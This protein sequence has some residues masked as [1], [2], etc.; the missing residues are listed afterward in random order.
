MR[1]T[2]RTLNNTATKY[3]Q[4]KFDNALAVLILT[5]GSEIWNIKKNKQKF[6]LQKLNFRG[7]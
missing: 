6:K 3:T 5:Y 2:V 4:L 1:S 7:L